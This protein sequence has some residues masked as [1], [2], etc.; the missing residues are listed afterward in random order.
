MK[1]AKKITNE[2]IGE[3]IKENHPSRAFHSV[4]Y[5]YIHLEKEKNIFQFCGDLFISLLSKHTLWNGNKR[6][7]IV[8]IKTLLEVFGYYFKWTSGFYKDYKKHEDKIVNFIK[9][10]KEPNQ[11]NVEKCK[12]NIYNWVEKNSFIS[13]GVWL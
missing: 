10:L 7:S 12:K 5:K 6:T 13:K 9:C 8:F 3:I 11:K 4:I 1:E 2:P